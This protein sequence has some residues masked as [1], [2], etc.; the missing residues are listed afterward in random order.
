MLSN[1]DPIKQ[2]IEVWFWQKHDKNIYPT[3]EFDNNYVQLA[4]SYKH[5]GLVLESKLDLNEHAIN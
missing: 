5:L 2:A 1:S 3:L 4:N